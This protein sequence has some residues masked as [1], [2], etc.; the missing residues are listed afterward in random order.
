MQGHEAAGDAQALVCFQLVVAFWLCRLSRWRP[1]WGVNRVVLTASFLVAPCLV[2]P[3]GCCQFYAS[4]AH[5]GDPSPFSLFVHT[6]P[7]GLSP[8]D[9]CA[10]AGGSGTPLGV[11]H[12][13]ARATPSVVARPQRSAQFL[14]RRRQA[15]GEVVTVFSTRRNSAACATRGTAC[16]PYVLYAYITSSLLASVV[17]RWR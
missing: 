4:C 12:A 7:A 8:A 14:I 6:L 13:L 17:I 5:C 3:P 11:S 15:S 2:S 1:V 10:D 9:N 16:I